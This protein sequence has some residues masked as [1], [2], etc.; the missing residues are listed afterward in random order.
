MNLQRIHYVTQRYKRLQ[1]LSNLPF[2]FCLLA[3]GLR[4][5]LRLDG[6]TITLLELPGAFTLRLIDLV[7][8]VAL[9]L[10]A[11]VIVLRKPI[12]ATYQNRYGYVESKPLPAWA[13]F[14][15]FALLYGALFGEASVPSV[16]LFALTM[17][18]LLG[19]LW[20]THHLQIHYAAMAVLLAVLSPLLTHPVAAPVVSGGVV[21][22][23]G[24]FDHLLL[25]NT[26]TQGD[27]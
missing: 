9:G 7:G 26:F 19:V 8:L 12:A 13:W 27:D 5:A 6:Q 21:L 2:A 15:A 22:V 23:A 4:D 14:L 3:V 20:Q 25:V 18:L 16:S 10:M 11:S 24:I 1:G 17:S